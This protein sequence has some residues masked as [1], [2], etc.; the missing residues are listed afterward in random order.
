[1]SWNSDISDS[2][3]GTLK[4]LVLFFVLPSPC[5]L[6]PFSLCIEFWDQFSI[7]NW[8]DA[9]PEL[10][11][12]TTAVV[13]SISRCQN[14]FARLSLANRNFGYY[15]FITRLES[16]KELYL[17]WRYKKA[18]LKVSACQYSGFHSDNWSL[19]RKHYH[20]FIGPAISR[21]IVGHHCNISCLSKYWTY[22]SFLAILGKLLLFSC[23]TFYLSGAEQVP[24]FQSTMRIGQSS[25]F[26]L[27]KSA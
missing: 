1:M 15:L 26:N 8:S 21:D 24:A 12:E 25:L 19:K 17:F 20:G 9:F 7:C 4:I 6:I 27:E 18:V 5:L 2:T 13:R 10:G 3:R 11:I 14:C 22:V 23:R 16:R